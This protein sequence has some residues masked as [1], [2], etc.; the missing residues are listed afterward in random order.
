MPSLQR[1]TRRRLLKLIACSAAAL[2]V[3]S[4]APSVAEAQGKTSKSAAQYQT[5]PHSGQQCSACKHFKAPQSCQ[6]VEGD[7]SPNGWCV[8]YAPKSG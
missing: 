5:H 3:A 7:I 8:L 6:L 2:P 4:F 1:I